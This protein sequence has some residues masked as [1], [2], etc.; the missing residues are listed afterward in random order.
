MHRLL[1]G[2]L[3]IVATSAAQDVIVDT[4]EQAQPSPAVTGTSSIEGTVVNDATG[5]PVKKAQVH[6]MGSASPVVITDTSGSF[7]FHKLPAGTYT[8]NAMRDGFDQ[9]RAML[10]GDGQRQVT[11]NADQDK[12]GVELRLPPTGVIT[13]RVIDENGDPAP[14]C[15]VGAID[16][17]TI[18]A[19]PWQQHGGGQAQT[20]DRG[21]YRIANLPAGRYVVYQHCQRGIA[22]PHGFMER[23]DPRRPMWAWVP[24]VYG[25]A[26]DG[27]GA[28]TIR[29]HPGEEVN[30]IDFHLKITSA[31][32]V[33]V[34]VVPD[35][36]T[37]DLQNVWVRLEARDSAMARV[38]QYGMGRQN[39]GAEFR[40]SP[41]VPGSYIAIADVQ[42]PNGHWHG[43]EPVEVRNVPPQPVKLSLTSAITV[44]GDLETV[45]TVTSGNAIATSEDDDHHAQATVSL[46]PLKTSFNGGFPQTQPID[47]KGNFSITGVLPGRYQLE[48]IGA[49]NSIRSVTLAGRGVSPGAID[50]GPGA[51][52]PLHVVVSMKQ[53]PV[54][55]SVDNLRQDQQT[56]VFLL[57]KGVTNPFPGVNPIMASANQSSVSLQAP[58]GEYVA[59]AVECAQPWPL[60]NN[61]SVLHAI[62][63]LG[64]AIEVKEDMTASV[65][66]SVI[67]REDLKR[68]L[69][70]DVQ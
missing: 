33:S 32:H 26:D 62:S 37:I 36:P 25:G 60:L 49:T 23:D 10:L 8:I 53:V 55:V 47:D 13:G 40:A 17:S 12:S 4:P 67:A 16:A 15:T 21:E 43:E 14:H 46:I 38:R 29:V 28:S 31:F 3:I 65:T 30:G 9:N 35:D 19:F 63:G 41:V 58:P 54:Q 68:A 22:A 66:V 50:I 2:L 18:D 70:Q 51:T 11:L 6:L 52:G 27:A 61:S 69:D 39:N 20:D 1:T 48:V 44:S 7:A 57:P 42:L 64:K 45:D 24:G 59:Y 34:T 5:E 56:W